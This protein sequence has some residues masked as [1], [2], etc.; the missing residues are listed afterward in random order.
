VR[1]VPGQSCAVVRRRFAVVCTALIGGVLALSSVPAAASTGFKPQPHTTASPRPTA[2]AQHGNGSGKHRGSAKHS[3]TTSATPHTATSGSQTSTPR[4]A[5][6]AAGTSRT[7]G[8]ATAYRSGPAAAAAAKPK[9]S[10]A[11]QPEPASDASTWQR[12]ASDHVDRGVV[13]AFASDLKSAGQSAGFPVLLVAVMV[14]FLL[15]QHRLDK[16]DAKLSQADWASDHGLEF[17]A[18]ATI[19]R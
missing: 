15:V 18:P 1:A 7:S 10:S 2:T 16:R 12:A 13:K 17:S 9:P 8:G 11:A 19:R 6:Q 14:A 3:A 4:T 5:T